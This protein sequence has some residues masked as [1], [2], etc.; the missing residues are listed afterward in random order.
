MRRRTIKFNKFNKREKKKNKLS[1]IICLRNIQTCLIIILIIL[2]L[3]IIINKA[4]II[5]N[6]NKNLN[7]TIFDKEIYKHYFQ[8]NLGEIVKN[9]LFYDIIPGTINDYLDYMDKA[10]HGILFNKSNLIRSE[11]PKVSLV[12]SLFNRE[13]FVNSTIRSV[14]NQNITDLE[15]IIVDDCSTDDSLKYAKNM[16]KND[17]RIVILENKINKGSLYSKSIGVLHARGKYV[18]SLDSDD[19]LCAEDYLDTLYKEAIKGDYD[20]I[21]CE[22]IYLD[23]RKKELFRHRPYW[24]VLW[25]KLIKTKN[26]QNT[27]YKVGK[28]VLENQ[29]AIFDDDIIGTYLFKGIRRI[30]LSKIGV[31]HF[32]HFGYHIYFSELNDKENIERYCNGIVNAADSFYKIKGQ[33]RRSIK[34]LNNIILRGTCKNYSNSSKIQKLIKEIHNQ[35]QKR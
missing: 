3:N 23:E 27:I 17:P 1:L 25:S 28:E 5:K 10:R 6:K 31:C 29:V 35:E 20:I 32:T 18:Y 11:N 15:I 33:R 2:L 34:M 26:Y 16:Q 12:I 13:D 14:Q 4:L 21:D 24:T 8:T 7:L 9:Y 22:A 30:Y 19:M